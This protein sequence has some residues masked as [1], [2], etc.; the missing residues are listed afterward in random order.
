MNETAGYIYINF[1]QNF[2]NDRY[3]LAFATILDE[4]GIPWEKL[5]YE[6]FLNP[7]VELPPEQR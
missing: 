2:N 3:Y 6:T 5:P 1:T 4:L 7:E